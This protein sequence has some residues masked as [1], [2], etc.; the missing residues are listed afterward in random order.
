MANPKI[1]LSFRNYD[2]T[3]AILRGLVKPEGMDLQIVE[4][5]VVPAMF[6]AMF[7]G[8]YDASEMSLSELVYY[9]SRDRC[10]FIGVP[11]FPVRFF[12]HSYILC[13]ASSHIDRP[14]DLNGKRLGF[15]RWSQT[16]AI[17][18]RGTLL[19]E[20]GISP[21]KTQWYVA[22]M[23]HWDD[24]VEKDEVTPRDD[25]TIRWLEKGAKTAA[26][27]A[28]SALVE[29]KIDALGTTENPTSLVGKEKGIKRLFD[30]YQEVEAAYF[31][32]TKIF[33][34]MHVLV[35]RKPVVER[36]PDVPEKLFA[37][38]SQ[39]KKWGRRWVRSHSSQCLA[40]RDAYLEAEQNV[41][42]CDPW[43]YGVEANRHVIEKFLSYCYSQGI[44]ARKLNP[45][46]LFASSTWNL[47]EEP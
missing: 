14:E 37:L 40:W 20:Y 4:N 32:K 3:N 11:V 10:E 1:I 22:T 16:A 47:T 17:W 39:S 6:T 41:F 43:A 28:Y 25:F 36:H 19:D 13:N 7:K 23:H 34:I 21:G 8:E 26:Q 24:G 2:G 27:A 5:T 18:M 45:E 9:T 38:F 44:S 30:N 31:R 15:L 29:G 46:D 12:R 33:P 35:I 42:Q